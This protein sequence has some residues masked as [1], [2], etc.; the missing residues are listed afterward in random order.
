MNT[1]VMTVKTDLPTKLAIQEF[2]ESLGMSVSSLMNTQM[3]Q[4]LR[5]R[6]VLLSTEL[7]PTNYLINLMNQVE[8]DIKT[9]K[10]ITRTM[11][12]TEA[13]AYLDT[14]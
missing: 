3:R 5:D 6:R 12:K 7:E 4:L 8:E 14:L 10:N 1:A 13:L 9:G 11:N 2:A